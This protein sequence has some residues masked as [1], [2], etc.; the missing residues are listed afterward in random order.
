VGK[1]GIPR[2]FVAPPSRPGLMLGYSRMNHEKIREGGRLL[3][4][5]F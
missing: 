3:G 1:Y 4:E 2:C 5:S